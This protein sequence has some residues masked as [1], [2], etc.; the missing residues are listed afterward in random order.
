MQL[1]EKLHELSLV[2]LRL[3][4][5]WE[6]FKPSRGGETA[7]NRYSMTT[8]NAADTVSSAIASSP[9]ESLS[10][11]ASQRMPAYPFI[12]PSGNDAATAECLAVNDP[13]PYPERRIGALSAL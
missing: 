4:R 2:T 8:V 6:L 10:A 11:T 3:V 12:V 1:F 13:C 9:E 5:W 7:T